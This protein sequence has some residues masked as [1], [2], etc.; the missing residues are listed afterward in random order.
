M[1]LD[2]FLILVDHGGWARRDPIGALELPML[3]Q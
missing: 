2:L 1:A 3:H